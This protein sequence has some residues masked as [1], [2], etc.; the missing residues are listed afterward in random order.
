M[1]TRT[2]AFLVATLTLTLLGG[3]NDFLVEKPEDFF[4]PENFPSTEADLKIALGG[5]DNWYTGGT[6]Q[7]YFIRGW[8]MMTE[9]PSDQTVYSRPTDVS[10]YEQDTFTMNSSNEWLWRVWRQ[11]YGAINASN[12]L[13]ERIPRMTAVPQAVKDRY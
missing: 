12:L 13:I 2:K 5:I 9:V 1:R 8:P 4:S 6:N 11:I 10:R 7:P 3:C